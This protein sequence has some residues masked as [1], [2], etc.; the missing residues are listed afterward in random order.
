LEEQGKFTFC[1]NDVFSF[2]L[3]MKQDPVTAY[4]ELKKIIIEAKDFF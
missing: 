4:N 2:L 1:F 3:L